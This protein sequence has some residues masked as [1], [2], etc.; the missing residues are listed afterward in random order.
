MK[1]QSQAWKNLERAVAELFG[2]KRI[3]RA[4]DY[5]QKDIDV[6]HPLL[7]FDAKY[8]SSLATWSWFKKLEKDIAKIEKHKGKIPCLILKEKGK[9]GMLAVIKAETLRDLIMEA[10]SGK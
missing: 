5:S 2:G 1:K 9:G 7:A 8:R 6:E 3:T 10:K 4:G